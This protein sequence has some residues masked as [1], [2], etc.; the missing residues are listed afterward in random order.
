MIAFFIV[1]FL[2]ITLGM[3]YNDY[4]RGVHRHRSIE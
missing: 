3:V 1:I 2:F 4:L